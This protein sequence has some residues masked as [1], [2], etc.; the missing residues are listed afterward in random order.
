MVVL[1]RRLLV[2]AQLGIPFDVN[3][4]RLARHHGCD[5]PASLV[6]HAG[7]KADFSDH[8]VIMGYL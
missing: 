8:S 5:L 3:S 2:T 7:P 4:T 1:D 6:D